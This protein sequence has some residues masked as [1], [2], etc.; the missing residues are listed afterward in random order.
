MIRVVLTGGIGSGK[1]TVA[2]VFKTLGVPIYIAD[3]QAK[4][5]MLRSKVIR[6]KLIT[7][8]GE[9]AYTKEGL[10]KPYLSKAI[11]NDKELLKKINAIVHPKVAKHFEKWVAK[12][13]TEYVIKEAAIVFENGSYKNY[14]YIITIIAPREIRLQRVLKRDNSTKSKVEAIMKNQWEDDKK[15]KLSHFVIENINLDSMQKQVFDIHKKLLKPINAD[16]I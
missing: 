13:N 6:R 16:E 15:I 7:L 11:F 2:N 1:T 4:Q 10:N 8:F 9:D 5:L 3:D 14:D 12:Q